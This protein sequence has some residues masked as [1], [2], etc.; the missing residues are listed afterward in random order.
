ML[1]W[2]KEEGDGSLGVSVKE[3]ESKGVVKQT[4]GCGFGLF[5]SGGKKGRTAGQ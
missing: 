2:D 4:Y 1:E 5:E 3:M